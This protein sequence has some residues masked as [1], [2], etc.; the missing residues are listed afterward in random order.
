[1]FIIFDL[2]DTL[3]DTTGTIS[4]F[5]LI[6]ALTGM[7]SAGLHL[8]DFDKASQL[9]CRINEMAPS[10]KHALEEFL[11]LQ[12]ADEK[13]LEIGSKIFYSGQLKEYPIS[14]VPGAIE[15]LEGLH[16]S[17]LMA[18][19]SIGQEALQREKMKRSGIAEKYFNKIVICR[20]NEKK[21]H[22]EQLMQ[23]FNLKA[24]DF[25][26]CGDRISRDL[27]PAKELG[28][29]T[30]Q[31]LWGRGLNDSGSKSDRDYAILALG[32]LKEILLA[33]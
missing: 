10:G 27:T 31:L 7:Q 20:E 28:M 8:P 18:V 6:E 19:V 1:M 11:Q 12:G 14:P 4:G 22:Y 33:I 26:V 29:H 13:F 23:Q 5:K 32:Q 16:G 3:V 24:K 15:L 30:V 21:M 2:D 17:H 25:L 9:L